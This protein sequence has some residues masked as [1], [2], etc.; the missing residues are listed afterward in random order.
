M[1]DQ[2]TKF[3]KIY[4]KY[5][6][7]IY[8]FTYLKLS[9]TE[10]AEDVTANIFTK[11]WDSFRLGQEIENV[12]AFI[13]KVA[14]NEIA[15]HYRQSQKTKTVSIDSL[16]I[17]DP[18]VNLEEK[19]QTQGEIEK[20]KQALAELEDEYQDIVIWRYLDGLSVKK[21]A[22]IIERPEGTIRVMAHRALKDLRQ[23][24]EE[25]K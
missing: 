21:I 17:P 7:K 3:A 2:K 25:I 24:L 12:Q 9:S 14:R 22:Q 6:A 19:Y 4:D 23:K 5:I 11:V 15:N 13:Y 10:L 1:G 18:N 16:Q 20:L 8:R